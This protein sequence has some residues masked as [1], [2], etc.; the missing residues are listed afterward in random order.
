M[1][2]YEYLCLECRREFERYVR[3]W[4]EGV[5]CPACASDRVEKQL[6]TFAMAGAASRGGGG[7]GCCGGGCGCH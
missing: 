1:P 7:G 6:S 3:T 4:S 2:V 5:A